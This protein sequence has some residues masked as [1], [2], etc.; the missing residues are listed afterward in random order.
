MLL[1][2]A[3][4]LSFLWL[5]NSPCVCVCVCVCITSSLSM[6]LLMDTE[7]ASTSWLL[8]IALLWTLG[9]MY[10]F[11][12]EVLSFLDP[13]PEVGLLDHMAT[14]VLVFLG[15]FHTVLH[16]GYTNLHFHQQCRKVPFSPHSLQHLLSVDFLVMSILIGMRWYLTVVLICVF[17]IISNV[18]HM[19]HF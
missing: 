10:R 6:H 9:C 12:L 2:M 13:C 14:L 1:Q 18:E 5:S 4:F 17:L 8:W 11:K 19:I 16:S 15:N 3:F 7:V